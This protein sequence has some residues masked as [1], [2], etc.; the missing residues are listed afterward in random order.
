MYSGH[1]AADCR[2]TIFG[3]EDY[4]YKQGLPQPQ[5]AFSKE[6]PLLSFQKSVP[7]RQTTYNNVLTKT[8]VQKEETNSHTFGFLPSR[9]VDFSE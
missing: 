3:L 2:H 7:S 5:K 1:L 9:W 6:N 4:K 8:Y